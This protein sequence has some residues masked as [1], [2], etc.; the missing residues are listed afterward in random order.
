MLPRT[1]GLW[2]NKLWDSHRLEDPSPWSQGQ[3]LLL[4]PP[5]LQG[6][7]TRE[8]LEFIGEF[9]FPIAFLSQVISVQQ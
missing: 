4:G 8:D 9:S 3:C 7:L 2:G 1:C 5:E 6:K